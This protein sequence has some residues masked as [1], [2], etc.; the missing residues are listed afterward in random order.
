MNTFIIIVICL[1]LSYGLLKVV[2]AFV[3]P[4]K[5]CSNGDRDIDGVS[6]NSHIPFQKGKI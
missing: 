1:S 2:D 5:Y 3:F 6:F 4:V